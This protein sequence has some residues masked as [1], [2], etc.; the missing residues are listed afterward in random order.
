M[1]EYKDVG[2]RIASDE[3]L[4][5][6]RMSYKMSLRDPKIEDKLFPHLYP[7]GRGG[8]DMT[9]CSSSVKVV[10]GGNS[11]PVCKN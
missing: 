7:F 4:K 3:D 6:L 8:F 11:W 9:L 2:R 10:K 1:L 5:L